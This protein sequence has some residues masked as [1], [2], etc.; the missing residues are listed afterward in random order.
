MFYANKQHILHTYGGVC[1]KG[2]E[3]VLSQSCP[4]LDRR[5]WWKSPRITAVAGETTATERDNGVVQKVLF[6]GYT[7]ACQSCASQGSRASSVTLI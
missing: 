6:P 7:G 2:N 4:V 5:T 3:K 1:R